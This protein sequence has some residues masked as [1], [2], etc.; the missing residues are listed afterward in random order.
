MTDDGRQ[1]GF[2]LAEL[3]MAMVITSIILGAVA[4][5]AYA[6][7]V[8]NDAGN[9]TTYKQAQVRYATLRISELIRNCRLIFSGTTEGLGIWRADNNG[10]G[11]VDA[12]EVVFLSKGSGG[13]CL[14]F[15]EFS[16]ASLPV[17]SDLTAIIPYLFSAVPNRTTNLIPECSNVQFVPDVSPPWTRSVSVFFD[18]QEG[19]IT[20][21]YQI[22]A[23]LRAWAGHLLNEAG[24]LVSGDDDE[25]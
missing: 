20:H 17:Y 7:G 8:A 3:L 16:G 6:M 15:I 14:R 23:T 19:G 10:N 22:K 4:T 1:N 5:L 2:T 11:Q 9:D 24:L 25:N 18:L 12:N 13:N 21:R